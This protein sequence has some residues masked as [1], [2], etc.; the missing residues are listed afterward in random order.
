M[1]EE[2]EHV[3]R[4]LLEAHPEWQTAPGMQYPEEF[5]N[6]LEHRLVQSVEGIYGDYLWELC[7]D[8]KQRWQSDVL[9]YMD[10]DGNGDVCTASR[11]RRIS[12]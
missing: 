2:V 11:E 4:E 9:T 7:D 5:I 10:R 8:R 3:E 6:V 12:N 1:D